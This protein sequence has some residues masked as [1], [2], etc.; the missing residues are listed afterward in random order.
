MFPYLVDGCKKVCS[1]WHPD[2]L[3]VDWL[4]LMAG[5]RPSLQ[6][7]APWPG[8]CS[9][10]Q[11]TAVSVQRLQ[12]AALHDAA[13]HCP[14]LQPP[15]HHHHHHQLA[16]HGHHVSFIT[17]PRSNK[18]RCTGAASLPCPSCTCPPSWPSSPARTRAR[19]PRTPP[20]RGSMTWRLRPD[21][22]YQHQQHQEPAECLNL[23]QVCTS[24]TDW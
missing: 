13:G 4:N 8:G 11:A 23:Q 15:H 9:S 12:R 5:C 21:W 7:A 20:G 18:T 17:R 1:R 22:Q 14:P 10:R 16:S 2:M 3:V 24:G 6:T 19:P